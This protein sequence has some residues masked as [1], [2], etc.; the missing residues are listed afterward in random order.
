V[1]FLGPLE[2]RIQMIGDDDFSGIWAGPRAIVT[3]HDPYDP[4][5]WRPLSV[6]LGT[7][8]F[9]TPVYIYPPWVG[10]PLIPLGLLPLPVASAV[11]LVAGLAGAVLALRLALRELLP[12]RPGDHAVAAFALLMSWVGLLS[13][14]LGQWGY[15]LVA[16]LFGA[17]LALRRGHPTLAGL[18]ALAF[19]AKPQLFL[20]TAPAFAVHA[21]WPERPG[22]GPPR[23]GVRA[24]GVMVA[25]ALALVIAGWLV[26]PSWWPTWVQ[27]VLPQQTRPF[28][29]TV[30]ALLVT[31]IGDAGLVLAPFVVLALTAVALTFHPRGLAWMAV[32]PVLSLLAAPYTNSYDQIV[33]I[34]PIVL[35]A[36]VLHGRAPRASRAVLWAGAAVLLVA[37]PLMY[38]VA[39]IR[40]SETYGA[41]VS[42]A[43]FAIVI[44]AL[45]RYRRE[46]ATP[47]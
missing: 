44:A 29:D 12:D 36:G 25:G 18:A 47:E 41:L 6:A 43:V 16:A 3:G 34:V 27:I 39:L 37:T 24:V 20:L 42:L 14:I 33:L 13:L 26:T 17:V 11:W 21:L 35:A 28:S 31:L 46:G 32:W 40:H 22:Q 23:D 5:T 1:V 8:L 30:P 38:R 4:S 2:R 15:L 45:W 19:L 7:Q 9:N 10:V